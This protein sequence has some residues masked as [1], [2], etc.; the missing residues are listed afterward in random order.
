MRNPEL[1]DK[2]EELE[3]REILR[4]LREAG[5]VKSRAARLLGLTERMFKYRIQ[6]YGILITKKAVVKNGKN[7]GRNLKREILTNE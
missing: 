2:V 7:A 5:W 4:A 3:I 6:K 1:K